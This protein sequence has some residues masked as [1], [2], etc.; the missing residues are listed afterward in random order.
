MVTVGSCSEGARRRRCDI[1]V[2]LHLTSKS[3][4]LLAQIIV[5]A[6]AG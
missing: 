2:S 4:A 6:R 5:I 1:A 3:E